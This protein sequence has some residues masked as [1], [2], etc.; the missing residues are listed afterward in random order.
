M[1]SLVEITTFRMESKSFKRFLLNENRFSTNESTQNYNEAYIYSIYDNRIPEVK[2]ILFVALVAH[3]VANL[4][5][6][7]KIT[8]KGAFLTLLLQGGAQT[9]YIVLYFFNQRGNRLRESFSALLLSTKQEFY[10]I[11]S[12]Q[13][14]HHFSK[15]PLLEMLY[16]V[17]DAEQNKKKPLFLPG[18]PCP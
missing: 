9:N 1:L 3:S 5:Q 7:D 16:G 17:V 18:L 2:K 11:G 4:E 12:L 15:I 8:S 10:T 13:Q 6:L 14:I